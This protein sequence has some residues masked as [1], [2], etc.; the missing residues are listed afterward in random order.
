MG[1][2]LIVLIKAPKKALNIYNLVV[3]IHTYFSVLPTLHKYSNIIVFSDTKQF[4]PLLIRR[5]S[6]SI[7]T[8]PL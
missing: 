4:S 6:N 8:P 3:Y 1:R 2:D 7:L 5:L